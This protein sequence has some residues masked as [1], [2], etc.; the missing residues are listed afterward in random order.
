MMHRILPVAAAAAFALLAGCGE[1]QP[2]Q[3]D[4]RAPDPQASALRNAAPVELPPAMTASVTFR[5]KDNSLVYVDFFQ[6][7]KLA[8]FRTERGTPP[9]RLTAEKDGDPLTA[10]G[11]K[12]TGTQKSISLTRPGKGEMTCNA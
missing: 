12:L 7:N 9:V 8:N 4:S 11:Y 6:G 1:Q 5:C 3:V 2:E 10:D